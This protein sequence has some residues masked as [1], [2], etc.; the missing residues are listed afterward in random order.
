MADEDAF[1]IALDDINDGGGPGLAAL[2]GDADLAP[3][4]H[5]GQ[6][7]D[8]AAELCPPALIRECLGIEVRERLGVGGARIEA[9]QSA[10]AVA[11]EM[12]GELASEPFLELRVVRGFSKQ[13]GTDEDLAAGVIAAGLAAQARLG[14]AELTVD[15]VEL[16]AFGILDGRLQS[17][18]LVLG[19]ALGIVS[20]L[21]QLINLF[22]RIRHRL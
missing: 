5:E 10:V 14:A 1:R 12:G 9:E 22:L 13:G 2:G 21:E 3:D 8:V 20:F 18:D 6:G 17:G 7:R 15:G 4:E 19:G 16:L 11:G